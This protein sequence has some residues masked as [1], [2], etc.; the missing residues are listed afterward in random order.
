MDAAIRSETVIGPIVRSPG[1][2]RTV[3]VRFSRDRV[4]MFAAAAL[5]LLAETL[6]A[7]HS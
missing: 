7:A 1:Y 2:W 3:A 6:E 4:A 5:E